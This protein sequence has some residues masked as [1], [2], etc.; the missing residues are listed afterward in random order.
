LSTDF[1]AGLNSFLGF[2][3]F[4]QKF[5]IILNR[6]DNFTIL[7]LLYKKL[8][9]QIQKHKLKYVLFIFNIQIFEQL[10]YLVDIVSQCYILIRLIVWHFI[11]VKLFRNLFLFLLI[12]WGCIKLVTLLKQIDRFLV[13]LKSIED[14]FWRFNLLSQIFI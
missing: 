12:I 3:L 9:A 4:P 10:I 11:L 2:S 14:N 8:K 5:Y 7:L 6:F 13:G 1:V